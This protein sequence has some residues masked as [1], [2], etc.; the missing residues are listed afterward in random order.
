MHSISSLGTT[1][2]A[3]SGGG[4]GCLSFSFSLSVR[5]SFFQSELRNGNQCTYHTLS[6]FSLPGTKS[7]NDWIY[8]HYSGYCFGKVCFILLSIGLLLNAWCMKNDDVISTKAV[9]EN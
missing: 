2:M 5:F 9:Y 8:I 3:I 7:C 4:D 6:I 1:G